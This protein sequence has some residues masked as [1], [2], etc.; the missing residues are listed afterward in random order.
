MRF[1]EVA[2]VLAASQRV[3]PAAAQRN[4]FEF[5]YETARAALEQLLAPEA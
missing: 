3:S 2:D 5:K 1:G 4:G